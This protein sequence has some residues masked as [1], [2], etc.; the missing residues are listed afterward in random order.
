L[1]RDV[2]QRHADVPIVLVTG[3][4]DSAAAAQREFLVLRKPYRLAELSRAIATVVAEARQPTAGNLVHLRDARRA[5][6]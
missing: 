2:R 1:A 4:S 6:K 5:I 3:Y